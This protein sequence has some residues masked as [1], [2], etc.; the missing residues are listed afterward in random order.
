MRASNYNLEMKVQGGVLLVNLLTRA[1]LELDED[2]FG[3]FRSLAEDSADDGDSDDPDIAGF[4]QVLKAGFFLVEDEFDEMA[5][6]R[7]RVRRERYD[8][9]AL[10]VVIAPTMGCN[11]GC[12]YCFEDRPNKLMAPE[13][14]L[15]LLDYVGRRLAGR[16]SLTVQWFGGEPL[17][18]LG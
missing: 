11:F 16:T 6:L 1:A 5:Y 4:L 18:A 3:V 14:E 10:A 9:D 8:S 7:E 17:Q 15:Q 13:A 12:H 2:S